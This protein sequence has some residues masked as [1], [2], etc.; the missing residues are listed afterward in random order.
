MFRRATAIVAGLA[1]AGTM[2]QFPEYSQQY[3]Q[4]MGGAVDELRTIVTDFD[5]SATEAGLTRGEALA[6]LSGSEFRELR[7]ED[8]ARTI[9]RYERLSASL[10]LLREERAAGRLALSY[11]AFDPE[12][13]SATYADFRPAI[14]VTVEGGSFALGG[15]VAG[16][17]VVA[18]LGAALPRR[19]KAREDA[20]V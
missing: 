6:D 17:G 7:S 18:G 11:G 15:F 12:I 1:G 19:R 13:A 4:R 16:W 9:S 8:M 10:T 5:A 3:I 2:A 20:S 14:P